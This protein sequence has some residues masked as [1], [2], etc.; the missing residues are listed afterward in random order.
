MTRAPF[1]S[2]WFDCDSTLSA[3][4]GIDELARG[5][6][7]PVHER[8]VGL[9]REAMDG[10]RPLA[11]VYAERLAAIA[12]TRQR[13]AAIARAYVDHAVP[14]AREVVA[15]LRGCGV[16]VGIVSGGLRP[17]VAG[18]AEWLG[19]DAAHVH[20]VDVRFDDAGR[21]AGFDERSPL[22]RNGGK[23]D[24]LGTVARDLRPACF[25]GDGATDL[26]AAP[27]VDLF[28]GFGGVVRRAAVER[29]ARH[30]L[31]GPGLLPL[32]DLVLTAQQRRALGDV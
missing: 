13:C 9:T 15:A 25:V 29:A 7:A 17:A 26:E 10:T 31:V 18:F 23:L 1:R 14:G 19:V 3:I 12:P 11:E 8:L 27:A 32:L 20:A 6:P 2:V 28:V 5:L 21:Y 4:E 24:V 30:Y 16:A 22:T